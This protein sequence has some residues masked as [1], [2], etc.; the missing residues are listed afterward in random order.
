LRSPLANGIATSAWAGLAVSGI[1]LGFHA[2]AANFENCQ[3]QAK[4]QGFIIRLII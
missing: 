1:A 2:E 3:E 4:G